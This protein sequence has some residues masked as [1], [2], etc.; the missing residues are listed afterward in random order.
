[1]PADDD[2]GFA[3]GDLVALEVGCLDDDEELI[4]VNL[5]T[6]LPFKASSTASGCR[7]NIAFRFVI[8]STVGSATPIQANSPSTC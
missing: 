6:C 8:S 7:P 2:A 3:I 4:A 5:G 1:M